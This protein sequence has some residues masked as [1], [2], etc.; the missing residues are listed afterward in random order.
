[1]KK[2]VA[3]LVSLFIMACTVPV[4]DPETGDVITNPVVTVDIL[5]DFGGLNFVITSP[6][7]FNYSN[8]QHNLLTSGPVY[9]NSDLLWD[10]ILMYEKDKLQNQY[11]LKV[12]AGISGQEVYMYIPQID[13]L[14][15]NNYIQITNTLFTVNG[16]SGEFFSNTNEILTVKIN[17]IYN[18]F[19]I[20]TND[21]IYNDSLGIS[22]A[23]DLISFTSNNIFYIGG[24]DYCQK[25]TTNFVQNIPVIIRET[26][27]G[28]GF[29]IWIT[30]L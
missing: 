27:L 15:S 19:L 2:I 18:N 11:T 12:E 25:V 13:F 8:V 16:Y 9:G 1:M 14:Y 29:S 6:F 30:N 3:V 22:S 21:N 28:W 20:I 23:V 24:F 4:L 17:G 10:K 7:P 26:Y 5:W